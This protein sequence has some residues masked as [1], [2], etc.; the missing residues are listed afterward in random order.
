MPCLCHGPSYP[1]PLSRQ[2]ECPLW[3][4]SGRCEGSVLRYP[5]PVTPSDQVSVGLG[6]DGDEI[7]AIDDVERAFGVKL[8][9]SDAS[10]WLTAGDVF[11]SLR[12]A[13]PSDERQAADLW[14][15]FAKA[16]CGVTGV[17][18]KTIE[19]AS[20]LLTSSRFWAQVASANAV[21]WIVALGSVAAVAV[22]SILSGP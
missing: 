7:E 15:R 16:L 12:K 3:V 22:A 10:Q 1:S 19:P 20:P 2:A 18:P 6:G 8:D 4:D 14:E 21:V 5:P 11:N 9:Y 13:L 17:D